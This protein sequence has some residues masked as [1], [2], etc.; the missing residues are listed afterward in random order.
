MKL[1]NEKNDMER[2]TALLTAAVVVGEGDGGIT[3][4]VVFR[5]AVQ[6]A[7]ANRRQP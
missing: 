6:Q 2:A 7:T 4:G 3:T 1:V 5:S